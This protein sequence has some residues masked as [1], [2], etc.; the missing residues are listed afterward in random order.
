MK[1]AGCPETRIALSVWSPDG[2]DLPDEI[3]LHLDACPTC[4]A[5]FAARFPPWHFLEPEPAAQPPVRG[6]TAR[7]RLRPLTGALA[8]A[9]GA[10]LVASAGGQRAAGVHPEAQM[11]SLLW[12]D[13]S[14]LTAEEQL[15][16]PECPM[17]LLDDLEL[18]CP[19]GD[20]SEWL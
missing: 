11:A 4:A 1:A 8:L 3:A 6:A 16:V 5:D 18:V 19:P 10:L 17:H 9:A 2:A 7:L 14:P 12:L 20:D 15:L 13:E